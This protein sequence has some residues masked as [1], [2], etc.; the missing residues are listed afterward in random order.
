MYWKLRE[1]EICLTVAKSDVIFGQYFIN[2][3]PSSSLEHNYTLYTTSPLT[4]ISPDD[5]T[6]Q[7]SRLRTN[8]FRHFF[9]GVEV[10]LT[11]RIQ[12]DGTETRY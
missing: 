8:L 5:I 4:V 1:G 3:F 10:T 2:L 11:N 6:G 7:E 9:R 12:E